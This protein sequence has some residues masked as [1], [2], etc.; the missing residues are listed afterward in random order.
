[1]PWAACVLFGAVISATD[2]VAVVSLLKQLGAPRSI[3]TLIEGE[4]L[5][6]DGTAVVIFFVALEFLKGGS[7]TF[8]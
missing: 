8:G 6:N 5:M 4:S 7:L 1:L 3:A 2:P